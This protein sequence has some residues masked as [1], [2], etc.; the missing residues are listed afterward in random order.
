MYKQGEV[1]RDVKKVKIAMESKWK[2]VFYY[3]FSSAF[4]THNE[5]K[6]TNRQANDGP[7]RGNVGI[8]HFFRFSPAESHKIS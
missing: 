1:D 5:P 8:F 4:S 3:H 2:G 7:I 6:L